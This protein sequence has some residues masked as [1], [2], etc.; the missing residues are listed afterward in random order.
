MN[1]LDGWGRVVVWWWFEMMVGNGW[2]C[3]FELCVELWKG[4]SDGDW[5]CG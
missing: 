5:V 1:L 3:V 4:G 2:V